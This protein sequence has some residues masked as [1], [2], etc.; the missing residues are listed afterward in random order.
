MN[1]ESLA[2]T[3]LA[4]IK[5]TAAD[6]WILSRLNKT[7]REVTVNMEKYELGLACSKLYDFVWNDFCDWY[8]EL[9]KPYLYSDDAAKK[10]GAVS[11]LV[12]VLENS[13][14]LLHPFIPFI[15]EEIYQSMPNAKG[16]IMIQD[17][18]RYNSKM[19]YKKES[20]AF[21]GIMQI[22]KSIRNIKTEVGCAPSKKVR[23][24]IKT[25]NK[26]LINNSREYIYK[27]AGVEDIIFISDKSELKEKTISQVESIAEI[28][29]PLGNL[30]DKDKEI[31]RLTTELERLNGEIIRANSKLVNRGFMDKAPKNLI[32]AERDKL[33]K[34]IELKDKV[35]KELEELK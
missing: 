11:V 27:L 6:K 24:F 7:V 12:F 1:T 21:E 16:S 8:I 25:E 19:S 31:I 34:Y 10:T 13:L 18:P 32:D 14:K 22:I 23:L 15:T 2:P 26:S 30:I 5:L 20:A 3:E 33:N 29:I 9:T 17:F 28:Y 35:T 4:K